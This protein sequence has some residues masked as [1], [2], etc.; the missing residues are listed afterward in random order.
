MSTRQTPLLNEPLDYLSTLQQAAIAC[1]SPA[2][3]SQRPTR[4]TPA[5]MVVALLR[6][7]KAAKQQRLIY[8]VEAVLGEWRLCFATGTRQVRQ[9]GGI[10]LGQGFY[11]PQWV[12]ASLSFEPLPDSSHP[13]R[14]MIGNQLELA[15]SRLKLRGPA[16]YWGK[17]NLVAFDFN[18]MQ[19]ELLQR[20]IY[21]GKFP[22]SRTQTETFYEQAIAHLP[23][24]AFFL[25]TD[26]LIAA[27]GRG[28]GLALWVNC[29]RDKSAHP[30]SSDGF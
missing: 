29:Q 10:V 20:T 26:E 3:A 23:F 27:R 9:R 28:G 4:P 11:L 1:Q 13:Q 5:V 16:H 15:N 30:P 24:F 2:A 22:G 14:F 12:K 17:K 25:I 18:Q 7:E 8:P 21:N 19:V 6:A